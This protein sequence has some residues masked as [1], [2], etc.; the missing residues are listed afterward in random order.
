MGD[1]MTF[2]QAVSSAS[3]YNYFNF[4]GRAPR[5]EFWWF[6]VYIAIIYFVL[7]I[8]FMLGGGNDWMISLYQSMRTGQVTGVYEIPHTGFWMDFAVILAS[9]FSLF[10]IIPQ[11]SVT[12]RRFHDVNL[13]AWWVIGLW[14]AAVICTSILWLPFVALICEA[15]RLIVCVIRGTQGVNK[16]G[17]D[18]L[19]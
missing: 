13:S 10:F 2:A 7:G 4:S 17:P 19:A 8:I 5:S 18:P 12:V 1:I 15:A 6:Q 3:Y 16:Y 9:V 14:G 11:I